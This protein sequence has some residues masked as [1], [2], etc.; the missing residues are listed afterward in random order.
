MTFEEDFPSLNQLI[1]DDRVTCV[2]I[3]EV[4][5]SCLDKQKVKEAIEKMRQRS[6][7]RWTDKQIEDFLKQELGLDK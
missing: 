1:G 5:K 6:E 2:T 4:S 3:T 7:N